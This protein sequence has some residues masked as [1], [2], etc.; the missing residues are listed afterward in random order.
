M[1]PHVIMGKQL[2]PDVG[3]AVRFR[4]ART[5]ERGHLSS[6]GA[7]R[8]GTDGREPIGEAPGPATFEAS[9]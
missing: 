8:P 2:V 4:L 3:G 9:A 5:R 1:S 6:R 7:R